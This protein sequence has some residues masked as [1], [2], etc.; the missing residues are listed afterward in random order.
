MD[1]IYWGSCDYNDVLIQSGTG[2]LDA[3]GKGSIQYQY[4]EE[5]GG[6]IYTYSMEVTDPDTKRTVNT[7]VSQ[8]LHTTDGYVGM[9]L[10]YWNT[11]KTGISLQ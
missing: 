3:Q 4:N 2:V 7:S 9:I 8:I 11:E 5:E 10:P 6:K 1:C